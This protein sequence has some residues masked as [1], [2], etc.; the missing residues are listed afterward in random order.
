SQGRLD[1]HLRGFPSLNEDLSLIKRTYIKESLNVEFRAEFF[2]LFNR[3]TTRAA[4]PTPKPLLQGAPSRL[5]PPRLD[6]FSRR[7]QRVA[8]AVAVA[9]IQTYCHLRWDCRT[10]FVI[11]CHGQSPYS[12]GFQ[13][14]E[15][16]L[17]TL[18]VLREIGLLIPSTAA[19]IN[20]VN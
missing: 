19:K 18:S 13:A 10:E 16:L 1:P 7:V 4:S 3:V 8:V 12:L 5:H 6:V 15:F 20:L 9:Q 11:L 2:N 17:E 14:R